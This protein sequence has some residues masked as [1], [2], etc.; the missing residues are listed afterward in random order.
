MQEM[1][2]EGENSVFVIDFSLNQ[3]LTSDDHEQMLA[4]MNGLLD[5]AELPPFIRMRWRHLDRS[6]SSLI[7]TA[8]V[9]RVT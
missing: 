4:V 3:G 9:F 2:G 6:F 1:G 5:E 8:C 7:D